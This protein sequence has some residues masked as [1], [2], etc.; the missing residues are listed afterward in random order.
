M[1]ILFNPHSFGLKSLEIFIWA[2]LI[3]FQLASVTAGL[4]LEYN[5]LFYPFI[6]YFDLQHV[7]YFIFN[8]WATLN[9]NCIEDQIQP[10][11][12]VSFYALYLWISTIKLLMV[13]IRYWRFQSSFMLCLYWGILILLQLCDSLALLGPRGTP[14]LL[15]RKAEVL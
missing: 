9:F 15:P 7:S 8:V 3:L 12:I 14:S 4:A 6:F 13:S 1:L 2:M 11:I 10:L 5:I